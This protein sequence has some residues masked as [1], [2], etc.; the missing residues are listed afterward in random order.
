MEDEGHPELDFMLRG[1]RQGVKG[2]GP[3]RRLPAEPRGGL[4]AEFTCR[5][6]GGPSLPTWRGLTLPYRADSI[7]QTLITSGPVL[8]EQTIHRLP[9]PILQAQVGHRT[10]KG[11]FQR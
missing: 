5:G 3:G 1:V 4:P 10:H 11:R 6:S 7:T 9:L 2:R 8:G